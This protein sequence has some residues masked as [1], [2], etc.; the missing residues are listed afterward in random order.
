MLRPSPQH[1]AGSALFYADSGAGAASARSGGRYFWIGRALSRWFPLMLPRMHRRS[2]PRHV[3]DT[4]L[5]DIRTGA[6]RPSMP[7]NIL[8]LAQ[9]CRTSPTPVREALS[10]LVGERLA[11]DDARGGY[12][13]RRLESHQLCSYYELRA[14]VFG[15]AV[16][17]LHHAGTTRAI[18]QGMPAAEI[19][20]ASLDVAL[21][22]QWASLSLILLPYTRAETA[23]VG[24][25]DAPLFERMAIER[26]LLSWMKAHTRLC[27]R[28][29]VAI[30][31]HSL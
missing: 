4:I 16:K 12:R 25:L 3:H 27:V 28:H 15:L 1:T 29:A 10:R 30:I 23:L 24:A 18:T 22:E 7:L 19:V 31:A 11:A 13:V 8:A 26:P 14:L 17:R 5:D 6:L 9:S 20:A 2:Q 21:V